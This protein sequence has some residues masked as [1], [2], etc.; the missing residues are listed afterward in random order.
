MIDVQNGLSEAVKHFWRTR[1]SQH[2][3]Q[4]LQTGKKDAGNR[5]AVTGGKHADGFVNL[6]A[7]IIKDAELPN[8][9]VLVHTNVRKQRT[10]P[11]FFRPCKEWDVVVTCDNNLLAVIEIKSQVG[12]FGNNFNN[13]VEEA[14]GSATDFWTAYKNGVFK[15]TAKPWLGYLFMLEECDSS[16]QPTRRID[17]SPYP[18]DERFQSLSY[19]QRY[20]MVCQRM[21]RELL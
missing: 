13:R 1:G 2:E 20:E 17:L 21:V 8:I 11:G 12:S 6:I 19:A 16:L 7:S 9:E 14:I 10:L 4:G 15:P 5:A 18:V 3:K